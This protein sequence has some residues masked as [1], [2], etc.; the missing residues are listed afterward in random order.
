VLCS[1]VLCCV[2]LCCVVLCCVVLCCVV[3]HKAVRKEPLFRRYILPLP[4]GPASETN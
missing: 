1:V 2:V 4:S 3:V